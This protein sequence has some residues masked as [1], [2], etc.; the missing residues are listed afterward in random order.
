MF[1]LVLD[2]LNL[3][4]QSKTLPDNADSAYNILQ[5]VIKINRNIEGKE[6]PDST[7]RIRNSH[8]ETERER[9]TYR[10]LGIEFWFKFPNDVRKYNWF[11]KSVY[12]GKQ[13]LNYWKKP[14]VAVVDYLA[15]DNFMS[16]YIAEIDY[17]TLWT[18]EMLM[19]MFR[20]D[21]FDYIIRN[22]EQV[23]TI[24]S[25]VNILT[26]EMETFFN[27]SKNVAFR[28]LLFLSTS[29]VKDAIVERM[30]YLQKANDEELAGFWRVLNSSL[31]MGYR[32]FGLNEDSLNS[33]LN[34]LRGDKYMQTASA[35]RWLSQATNI[36]G[37]FKK[38]MSLRF[39]LP[40][41]SKFDLQTWR[42]PGSIVLIDI[43]SL[44]CSSCI[45]RMRY[46]K[47]IY[48]KYRESG[49]TILSLC[50]DRFENKLKVD[51]VML[52]VKGNWDYYLIGQPNRNSSAKELWDTYGFSFVP[53]MFLLDQSGKV[54][55]YN[56][57]LVEGDIEPYLK[58]LISNR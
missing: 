21:Y 42:K 8:I 46:L 3:F 12:L 56:N 44:N 33:L 25:K 17:E 39:T 4:G 43:W 5:S 49:F 22:G 54:V 15:R 53:Q 18:W 31:L 38:P 32:S 50:A 37:L 10:K 9:M 41:G 13:G 16:S 35:K 23:G 52:R 51:A 14:Q 11:A 29:L 45:G 26:S 6:P 7:I 27:L 36:F 19:P 47:E 2:N 28:K 57:D 24:F 34:E 58:K 40:E 55:L 48:E 1:L 30:K 20:R